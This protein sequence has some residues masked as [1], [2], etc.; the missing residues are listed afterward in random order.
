MAPVEQL[1][2]GL[3]LGRVERQPRRGHPGDE[4]VEHLASSSGGWPGGQERGEGG[5]EG[6]RGVRDG[7]AQRGGVPGGVEGKGAAAGSGRGALEGPAGLVPA[8][9]D[10]ERGIPA[11][12][13]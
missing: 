7:A 4:A 13:G 2:Q 8:A 1:E 10:G 12:T 5:F 6:H 11:E 9:Q 3:F